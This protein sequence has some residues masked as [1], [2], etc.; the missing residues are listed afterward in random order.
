MTSM[1]LRGCGLWGSLCS[2]TGWG[3]HLSLHRLPATHHAAEAMVVG[4]LPPPAWHRPRKPSTLPLRRGTLGKCC[5]RRGQPQRCHD[6]IPQYKKDIK[7]LKSVQRRA[8]K[9]AKGREGKPYGEHLWSLG[10]SS[11]EETGGDLIRVYNF[12][13]KRRD[14]Y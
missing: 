7:L 11:L 13:M 6:M 1:E 5:L 10:L 9:M 2:S 12:L 3:L 8:T 4:H 14:R